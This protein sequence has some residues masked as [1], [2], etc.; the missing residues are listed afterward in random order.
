LRPK[1][2]A[3]QEKGEERIGNTVERFDEPGEPGD[4]LSPQ[5]ERTPSF[6]P[7]ASLFV[8]HV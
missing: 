6:W 8:A 1:S 7:L 5:P 3:G 4:D 2:F